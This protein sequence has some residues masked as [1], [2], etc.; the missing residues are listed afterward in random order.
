MR[1]LDAPGAPDLAHLSLYEFLRY[2]LILLAA[3]PRSGAEIPAAASNEY[4]AELT[5]SGMQKVREADQERTNSDAGGARPRAQ[6]TA[7]VD[8]VIKDA[9]GSFSWVPF[10]DIPELESLRHTWVLVRNERPRN[11]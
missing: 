4:Q 10:P 5:H 7:G 9:C 2:W 6:L 11:P 3:F 8:Y 1:P